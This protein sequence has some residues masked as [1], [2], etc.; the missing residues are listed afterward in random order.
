MFVLIWSTLFFSVRGSNADKGASAWGRQH[1]RD[2]G[3]CAT[4][5]ERELTAEAGLCVVI[6]CSFTTAA[7][8]TPKHII[9]YKC[10]RPKNCSGAPTIFHSNN[11][12]VQS[13]FEGRVSR[14]EP[15]V[16]Q[17]NCSIIINDLKESDSGFY[18]LRVT[19]E[20]NGKR[21]GSSFNQRVTVSVNGL[22]QKPTV[23]VPTLT[24][25]QQATLTCTAPGLC[26]GSV[27][28]ITWT[29]R[30]AGGTE[31]YITGNSTDF[32]TENLT[33]V[34]RR[35]VS[36]LTFNPSAEHHNTNFTCKI[37]F[38]GETTTEK[39]SGLKVNYVKEVKI[40]GVTTVRDGEALN[41]TCNV[42]S[43]P[44]SLIIWSKLGSNEKLHTDTGSANLV[45][46]NV[47]AGDAGQYV[48]TAKY[49]KKRPK[50]KVN[51]TVIY[52][53]SLQIIGNVLNLTCSVESFPPTLIVWKKCRSKTKLHSETYTDLHSDTGSATLVVYNV[54]TEHSGQYIC[55]AKY[56]NTTL[57]SYVN[58]I[59]SYKRTPQI[60][61][62][63]TIKEG[64]DLNLT[65]SAESVPP[66]IIM[67]SKL[68]SKANL[69]NDTG[70][71]TLVIP[72]VTAE[73]SGQYICTAKYMDSVLEK[74]TN[75]TVI[76]T[77]SL[78][79]IGNTTVK[80]GDVLNLTCM[81]ESFPPALIV[82]KKRSSNTDLHR[83]TYS[84]LHNDTG[85]ATL[86]VYNVTTEHSGQYICTAKYMNTTLTSYLNVT[87][88]WFSNIQNGSGCVLQSEVLT[89]VCISEGFPLP[90]INWPLLKNHTEY[91]VITTVSNH[92]VNSTVSLTVKSHGNSTVEC[93]RNNGNG[94]EREILLIH[95]SLSEK[96]EKSSGLRLAYLKVTIAFLT[97]VLF[98][99]VLCCLAKHCYRNKQKTS[100]SLEMRTHQ[101]DKLVYDGQALQDNLTLNSNSGPKEVEYADIDFSLLKRNGAREAARRQES[102]KTIYAEIKKAVEE[103]EDDA[104]EEGEMLEVKEGEMVVEMEMKYREPE[105][106]IEMGKERVYSTVN[107]VTD[108]I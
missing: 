104:E 15:D 95:Q 39:T 46:T 11:K 101:D 60:I 57:K 103:R 4:L 12:N 55:T 27:P 45:I 23:M 94:E 21:N 91:S 24:E 77:R 22:K 6:P 62:N 47:T 48:C 89:C 44:P 81:V 28:Q 99:A 37:H 16:S 61:G 97:G 73:H 19:G 75:V 76:Y 17:K 7:N 100:R 38:T 108:E 18:Q 3:I 68:S 40:T 74:D 87:V 50:D 20:W 69:H 29:W 105:K 1:C 25:G 80:E 41:L 31:S 66:S 82:W 83:G 49:M 65:C 90:T 14:L 56:L 52:T 33:D 9:W 36:T 102:T 2:R 86:V 79:I 63:T 85:S 42:H 51:V 107:D 96:H 84:E 32:K 88:S 67:W 26:S 71:A 58:V 78:H 64:D 35:Y 8:F 54:T 92:T 10:E 53:R 106:E 34:T 70:S 13:G 93:V 72:N 98:S 30:G 5:S 59:V 43:F